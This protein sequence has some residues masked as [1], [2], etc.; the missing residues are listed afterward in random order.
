MYIMRDL[1]RSPN[2]GPE[3]L[4]SREGLVRG[5]LVRFILLIVAEMLQDSRHAMVQFLC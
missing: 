4:K 3:Q 5:I 1:V 2:D